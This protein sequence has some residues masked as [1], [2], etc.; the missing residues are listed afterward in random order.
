MPNTFL[1]VAEIEAE[2]RAYILKHYYTHT[3]GLHLSE[4]NIRAL[5]EVLLSRGTARVS[6]MSVQA[7]KAEAQE[8]T[9]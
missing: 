8:D 5:V 1:S 3:N 9:E 2:A 7:A 4:Q 6:R